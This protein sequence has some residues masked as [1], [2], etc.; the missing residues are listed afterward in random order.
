MERIHNQPA[1]ILHKRAY[2]NTSAI[3]EFFTRDHGRISLVAKGVS[4]GSSRLKGILQVFQPLH[5]SWSR[6]SE[7]GTMIS[8]ETTQAPYLLIDEAL[9]AAMYINEILL[10]LTT[11]DDPHPDIFDQYTHLIA[12]LVKPSNLQISL[13]L[14][15]KKLLQELGYEIDFLWDAESGEAIDSDCTYE[16]VPGHGFVKCIPDD[17]KKYQFSGHI[18]N[19]IA[20]ANL[21]NEQS[22]KAAKH[23]FQL[24]IQQLLGNRELSTRE[25]YRAFLSSKKN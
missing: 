11:K 16:F 18:L 19:N 7:L 1:F 14:F 24:S 2:R 8:A 13:R 15:E 9:Y 6:K 20:N 17:R 12:D 25:L 3:L 4:S 5:I 21:P 22:L 23:I 10:K